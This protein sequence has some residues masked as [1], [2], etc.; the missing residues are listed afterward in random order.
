MSN[1]HTLSPRFPPHE[2]TERC[3]REKQD[4]RYADDCLALRLSP[5]SLG[6]AFVLFGKLP[7]ASQLQFVVSSF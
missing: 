2:Q 1:P 5:A 7:S 4:S 3:E 6:Y